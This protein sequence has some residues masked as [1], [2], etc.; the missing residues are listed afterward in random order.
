MR[1]PDR[2]VFDNSAPTTRAWRQP[3]LA[4]RGGS[5]QGCYAHSPAAGPPGRSRSLVRTVSKE[6]EVAGATFLSS[7]PLF[8]RW[9]GK[10][11]FPRGAYRAYRAYRASFFGASVVGK[12]LHAPSS[13]FF[14]FDDE[15]KRRGGGLFALIALLAHQFFS[16]S[17]T[18]KSLA[19]TNPRAVPK[20]QA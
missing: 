16:C 2:A 19:A 11:S 4:R 5:R 18:G 13:G 9:R 10:C 7:P 3:A 8:F 1:A 17:L 20:M 6:L 12:P 15:L 14:Y